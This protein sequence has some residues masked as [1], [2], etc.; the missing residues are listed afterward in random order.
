MSAKKQG[1]S[2]AKE[3]NSVAEKTV[4]KKIIDRTDEHGLGKVVHVESGSLLEVAK[5]LRGEGFD[6]FLFVSGVD[7]PEEIGLTYR[8]TATRKDCNDAVFI[9]TKVSK[10]APVIDSLTS[11]WPSASWHERETFDLFGVEFK[12]HPDLRRMFMPDNWVGYPLRKDYSDDHMIV[13]PEYLKDQEKKAAAAEK[14][15]AK[16][17]EKTVDAAESKDAEEKAQ[18]E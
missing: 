12:G 5:G 10:D 11:I 17:K 16:A 15:K 2:S 6:L 1:K 4:A 13:F 18:D 9:K 7:Y 3:K 14:S 8:L